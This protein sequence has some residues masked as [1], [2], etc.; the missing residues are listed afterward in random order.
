MA[1]FSRVL[2]A[3]TMMIVISLVFNFIGVG[4]NVGLGILGFGAGVVGGQELGAVAAIVSMLLGPG[5]WIIGV[6]GNMA[7]ILY[8]GFSGAKKGLSMVDCGLVG[9][10]I[11]A[12]VGLIMGAIQ[13]VLQ[14]LGIGAGVVTSGDAA[15]GLLGGMFGLGGVAIGAFCGIGVYLGGLLLNFAIGAIGGLVGGAK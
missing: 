3:A 15:T 13:I 9:L 14:L 12:V 5:L 2:G 7:I 6:L 4:I 1:N 11:Y 10:L 8:A